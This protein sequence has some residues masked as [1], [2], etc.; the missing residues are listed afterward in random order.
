VETDPKRALLWMIGLPDI[1]FLGVEDGPGGVAKIH[2][3]TVARSAGCPSCGVLAQVKDRTRVELVDLPLQVVRAGWCGGSAG[4]CA[5]TV[6]VRWAAGPK[7]T[8]GSPDLDSSS[9]PGLLGGRPDK[10][11]S[12]PAA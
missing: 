3:E 5:R 7:R 4:G 2:V 12:T 11:A 8:T 9:P 10:W 1:T 6:T